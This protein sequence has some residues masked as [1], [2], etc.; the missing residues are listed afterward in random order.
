MSLGQETYS[1]TRRS[2]KHL[3]GKSYLLVVIDS[4]RQVGGTDISGSQRK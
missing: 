3:I 4:N 1:F 2:Y